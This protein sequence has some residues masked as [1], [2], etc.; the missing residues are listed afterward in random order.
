[1]EY[2]KL[3][4]QSPTPEKEVT[5]MEWKVIEDLKYRDTLGLLLS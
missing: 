3:W 2:R 4:V 1:M 5:T